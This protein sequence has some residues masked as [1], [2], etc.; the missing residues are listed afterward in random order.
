MGKFSS[1]GNLTFCKTRLTKKKE[2][3]LQIDGLMWLQSEGLQ[4]N[5]HEKQ[6]LP[7]ASVEQQEAMA[8]LWQ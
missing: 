4:R 7:Q 5:E 2:S 8:S 1:D 6:N 3:K